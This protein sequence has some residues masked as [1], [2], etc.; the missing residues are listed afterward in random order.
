MLSLLCEL[1]VKKVVPKLPLNVSI[2]G[3]D[4]SADALN[5]YAELLG[6]I[7]PWLE[8]SGIHISLSL[9]LCNLTV[10]GEFSEVLESFFDD[11]KKHNVK[12]FLCV[13]SSLSGAG[14]EGFEQMHDSLK[15]AAARLSH[16]GRSSSWLWVEPHVGKPWPTKFADSV[17]LVLKKVPFKFFRKGESYDIQADVPLLT[18]PDTR[19]FDWHDPHNLTMVKSR[20]LVMA[21]KSE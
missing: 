8:T 2:V 5:F 12:R 18:N 19:N 16:K 17:R 9:A 13:I 3:V 14:K 6:R 11:A 7:T 10:S 21:F 4:H 20:V 15:I 1:R